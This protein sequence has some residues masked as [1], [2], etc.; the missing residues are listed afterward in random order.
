MITSKYASQPDR[1]SR[2]KIENSCDV[3]L[4]ESAN[5]SSHILSAKY[6]ALNS[7]S[8]EAEDA[9][10]KQVLYPYITTIEPSHFTIVGSVQ[11]WKTS[12]TIAVAS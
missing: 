1:S 6:Q 4:L 7:Y 9:S 10:L 12:K 8:Q 3:A 2:L 11:L 5:M